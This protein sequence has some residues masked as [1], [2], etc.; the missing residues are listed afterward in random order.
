MSSWDCIIIGSGPSGLGAAF[1]LTDNKPGMKILIID[2]EKYST[3]GLRNDCK[4]NFTYPIGFPVEYWTK[5]RADYYLD[6]VQKILSPPHMEKFNLDIY[7]KRAENLD[8]QLLSVKQAHLGTDG[9][10]EAYQRACCKA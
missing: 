7:Q 10:T 8:T 2:K 1:Y 9:G 6:K 4:M 5:D 3:G